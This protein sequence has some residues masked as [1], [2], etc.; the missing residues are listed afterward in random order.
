MDEL[1]GCFL[2]LIILAIIG[3]V[4]YW[5]IIVAIWLLPWAIGG[6]VILLVIGGILKMLEK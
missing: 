4:F 5:L 6:F 3:A 1:L 2:G